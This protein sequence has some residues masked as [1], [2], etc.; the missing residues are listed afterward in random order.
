[1]RGGDTGAYL[2]SQGGLKHP[3]YPDLESVF[4]KIYDF[5]G[6]FREEF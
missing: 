3:V 5:H 1:M 6:L 4:G 2:V